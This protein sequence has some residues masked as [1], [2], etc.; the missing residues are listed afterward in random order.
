MG[1]PASIYEEELILPTNQQLENL[2]IIDPVANANILFR[3]A[4]KSIFLIY[5]K[6]SLPDNEIIAGVKKF[7]FNKYYAV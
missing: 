7:E 4:A 2:D 5:P 6:C 1:T 3:L